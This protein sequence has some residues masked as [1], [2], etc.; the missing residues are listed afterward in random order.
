MVFGSDQQKQA[1]PPDEVG[2]LI[3][4][5]HGQPKHQHAW[6]F[7][8]VEGKYALYYCELCLAWASV[9]RPGE[10]TPSRA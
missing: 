10:K 3:F 6:M 7:N 4:T 2:L 8:R 1:G 5:Y 9:A